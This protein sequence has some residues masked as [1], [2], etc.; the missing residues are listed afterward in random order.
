V[1]TCVRMRDWTNNQKGAVA[2]LAIQLAAERA[3]IVMYK[4]VSEHSIADLLFEIG[5]RLLRVQIKWARL[6]RGGAVLIVHLVRTRCTAR[7]YLRTTYSDSEIDLVAAYSG[8]L[9]RCFLLPIELCAGRKALQLRLTPTR[10]NQRT[11]I[12]LAD[13]FKFE[14]AVAQLARAPAWH[15]GGRG[16]ESL[17][18]HSSEAV[19]EEPLSI[20][21]SCSASRSVTGCSAPPEVRRSA[22]PSAAGLVS[23][24]C[25]SARP[26]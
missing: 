10:N 24:S 22:S 23:G 18:L 17:Q 15:A 5:A 4:P 21:P 8:E 16:F 14:G 11:C 2:E 13:D 25:R 1:R 19:S 12:N 20:A 3:G 6:D 7:G 9:D 26:F